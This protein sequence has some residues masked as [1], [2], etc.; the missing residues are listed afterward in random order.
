RSSD[1][2]PQ[3]ARGAGPRWRARIPLAWPRPVPEKAMHM[4]SITSAADGALDATARRKIIDSLRGRFSGAIIE[5]GG[6]GYEQARTVWN[7]MVDKR[8]GLIVTC[9]ST[10]DVVAAVDAAREFGLAPSVRCGGHNVAG[11]AL[12]DGGMTIDL[13][14]LREVS[15]DTGRH[16]A[17]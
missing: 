9:T 3:P 7:A 17:Y 15:V 6:P 13:G 16:F 2:R 12:S 1:R 4:T 14:G 8:P 10:A 11:K 5:P